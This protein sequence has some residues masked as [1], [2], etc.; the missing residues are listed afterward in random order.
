VT[1]G[2]EA[3][4][5]VWSIHLVYESGISTAG[6]SASLPLVAALRMTHHVFDFVLEFDFGIQ[7]PKLF[8]EYG[9]SGFNQPGTG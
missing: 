4:S 6:P 9:A 1:P 2:A 7:F 5:Q 8:F 3:S